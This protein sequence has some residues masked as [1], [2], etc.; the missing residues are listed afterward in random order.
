MPIVQ[1]V[2][3]IKGQASAIVEIY[4]LSVV[5][6]HCFDHVEHELK[7]I[8]VNKYIAQYNNFKRPAEIG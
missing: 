5:E 1:Y 3:P 8:R 6:Y 2:M 7:A 4:W